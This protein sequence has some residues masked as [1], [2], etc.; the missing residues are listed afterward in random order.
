MELLLH[1]FQ[2]QLLV[3]L[4]VLARISGMVM[5][6]PVWGSRSMPVRVR[7][8]LAVGV[9]LIVAPLFW[10][11]PLQT[12]AHLI[13]LLVL[14]VCEFTIGLALGLAIMIYFAGLQLAGQV[15]GQMSGMSLADVVSPSF[16]SSVP[17][18]SQFLQVL[19]LAVF[20][21]TNGHHRVLDALVNSFHQMPPG[22]TH[23]GGSLIEGLVNMT[24]FSFSL[25]L[26]VAAPVMV[27]VLLSILIMGLI[28]RTLPQLNVLAVGFSVNSLV[29]LS[30]MLLS[31]GVLTRVFQQRSIDALELIRPMFSATAP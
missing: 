23:F 7:A 17:V 4:L 11:S 2:H 14:S 30:A 31:L 20:V 27:A 28:S 29:M 10:G 3:F 12:P 21:L 22:D 18:F 6:A 16:D 25:G 24:A 13:D 19:L 15:M 8:F 26:Q 9:S 5:L 1:I